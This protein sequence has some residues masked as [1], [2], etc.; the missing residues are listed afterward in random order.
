VSATA[1]DTGELGVPAP[2]RVHGRR[3]WRLFGARSALIGGVGLLAVVV[4]ALAGPV[5]W[6]IDP[7]GLSP[8][9]FVPPGLAHPIGTDDLGR[10]VLAR[11]MLA[12]WIS[13][14]IGL[15]SACIAT[16]FGCAVGALSGYFGG[17]VDEAMM[18]VA[19]VFQVIARFLLAIVVVALFGS[20][21]DRMVL[22]IGFLSWPG[23]ARVIRAQ[24]LV[25]RREAFVLSPTA[26]NCSSPTS[27]PRRSTSPCR[28]R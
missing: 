4:L 2:G 11:V 23:T 17:Q 1:R 24:V 12:A 5:L 22:V 15:L 8:D 13:L 18:G 6:R 26:R 10:D 19:E 21:V 28:T 27:Q 25:L 9:R 7:L 20:G 3:Q 16:P 14:Q